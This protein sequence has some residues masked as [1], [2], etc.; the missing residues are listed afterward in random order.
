M[1]KKSHHELLAELSKKQEA[2]QNRIASIQAKKRKDED[3]ILTR[4]KILI[5][6]YLI[7]KYKNDLENFNK[8]VQEMAP[9]K[10]QYIACIK[11]MGYDAPSIKMSH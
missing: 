8:L 1:P 3:R 7:E 10:H 4:K 2:I 6:A 5:G 9:L 11:S